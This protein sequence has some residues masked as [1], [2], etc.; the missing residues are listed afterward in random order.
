MSG[1]KKIGTKTSQDVPSDTLNS[2]TLAT[3]E[4]W[5][6]VLARVMLLALVLV[7]VSQG[8]SLE[9]VFMLLTNTD[10][11]VAGLCSLSPQA[12]LAVGCKVMS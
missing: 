3:S 7:R 8:S 6:L 9:E 2:R 4:R 1:R 11:L 12:V 5:T 10:V